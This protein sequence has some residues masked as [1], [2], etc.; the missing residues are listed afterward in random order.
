MNSRQTIPVGSERTM[1]S[2]CFVDEWRRAHEH[3]LRERGYPIEI[4]RQLT[5]DREQ[6]FASMHL[7]CCNEPKESQ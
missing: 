2:D 4:V 1:E 7:S 5:H 3:I 6:W